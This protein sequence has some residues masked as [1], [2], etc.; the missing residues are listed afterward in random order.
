MFCLVIRQHRGISN[1]VSMGQ[2]LTRTYLYNDQQGVDLNCQLFANATPPQC[3]TYGLLLYNALDQFT[4]AHKE[5]NCINTQFLNEDARYILRLQLRHRFSQL[6]IH[7][8]KLH[9]Q[10]INK[11]H[12]RS[13]PNTTEK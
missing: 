1:I 2:N 13:Q 4:T 5:L 12:C 9:K 11:T 6:E 8:G 10:T 3:Q 7:F